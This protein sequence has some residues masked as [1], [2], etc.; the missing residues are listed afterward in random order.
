MNRRRRHRRWPLRLLRGSAWLLGGGVLLFAALQ[1]LV[2]TDW[3]AGKAADALS[4]RLGLPVT[5]ERVGWTP[6]GGARAEGVSIAQPEALA[7]RVGEP[8]VEIEA[9]RVRPDYLALLAGR[10][11]A[12]SVEFDA[13]RV[14][15]AVEMLG[16]I[17]GSA[18][19]PVGEPGTL[20]GGGGRARVRPGPPAGPQASGGA[21]TTGPEPEEPPAEAS[22]PTPEVR[23]PVRISVRR[24]EFRL[25]R[26]GAGELAGVTG[27]DLDLP[28][29]APGS[30]AAGRI[31]RLKLLGSS[32]QTNV[33]VALDPAARV[34]SFL[35]P[36]ASENELQCTGVVHISTANGW[37]FQAQL[38]VRLLELDLGS[39]G[40]PQ[41][42]KIKR[43]NLALNGQGWVHAPG[44]WA[45][46]LRA[47]L[48][49]LTVPVEGI[50]LSFDRGTALAD[51]SGG[52]LRIPDA[53]L[54]GE[55]VSLLGN[56]WLNRVEAAAVVRVVVS[57][58]LAPALSQ[59]VA[60][61]QPGARLDWQRLEPGRR[62]YTDLRIWQ[63]QGG[64]LTGLGP[65]GRPIPAAEWLES[66]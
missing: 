58:T 25:V 45:G 54:V 46:R 3:A 18:A 33:E 28:L 52:V 57:E 40:A 22:T 15:V 5:V 26:A 65:E 32:I 13:P 35:F 31:D 64:W 21:S 7:A 6:W 49:E 29:F 8:L 9:C 51:W 63:E 50:G 23:K 42:G 36:K 47:E 16:A 39:V 19:A 20:A 30:E 62:A 56:G 66:P 38:G 48:G 41:G 61:R 53:R 37:P 27:V 43:L 14:R 2:S 59:E 1:F 17:A 34:V 55:Q 44:S 24:G 10:A 60:R 4:S 11:E 12:R